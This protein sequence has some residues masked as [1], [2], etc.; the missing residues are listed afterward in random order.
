MVLVHNYIDIGTEESKLHGRT[1]RS[2]YTSEDSPWVKP[3]KGPCIMN[4]QSRMVTT[5]TGEWELVTGLLVYM[6]RTTRAT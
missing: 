4:V 5:V 1:A 6:W 2:L 3:E